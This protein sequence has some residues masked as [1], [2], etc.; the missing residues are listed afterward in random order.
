MFIRSISA[1]GSVEEIGRKAHRL[2]ILTRYFN[3]PEGFVVTTKA[4]GIWR[5]EGRLSEE[6]VEE[7]QE[8]FY[9]PYILEGK[10]QVVA[11][12]SA[13]AE[14]SEKASFA[15]VF[16][17]VTDINSFDRL[18]EGIERV[19][20][21]ATSRKVK[22]Y[23]KRR[24]ITKEPKMA[25]VV[26]RQINPE[27]SGVLFTRSPANH[28]KALVE[29]VQGSPEKLISGEIS[30][31]RLSLPRDPSNVEDGLMKDLITLGPEV[32]ALFGKPQ[33]IE[34]AYDGTLWILQSRDI[35]TKMETEEN[36]AQIKGWH[37][38]KGIPASSGV[39]RG[40]A[41]FILDD[42]PPEE[43]ERLF[44]EGGILVTY[45]LHAEHYNI[46]VKASG[47]VTKVDSILSHPAIIAR[48]LGIPC[49]VGG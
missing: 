28:E 3:V 1:G 47:I 33:D 35:T 46:F 30:G 27:L 49:V 48:E 11:R 7:I 25:V 14:D 20:K 15:G 2:S 44:P 32:E 26:Q 34:W 36:K 21:S 22:L 42:Q 17:S 29:F 9:S 4:Y 39:S 31:K 38:L 18:L 6:L 5:K 16:E 12:S 45:V 13:T 23:M 8:Y 40:K 19:F 37:P 43:A 24:G 10:F 41:Y